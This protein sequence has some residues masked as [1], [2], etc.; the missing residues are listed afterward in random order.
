VSPHLIPQVFNRSKLKL[1]NCTLTTAEFLGNLANRVLVN[2]ASPNYVTLI[3]GQAIDELRK[4][5]LVFRTV[6]NSGFFQVIRWNLWM[7]G[8]TLPLA[9]NQVH[10]DP[11]QPR[12]KR[13]TLPFE[14]CKPRESLMEDLGGD[15]LG[16]F[17][18]GHAPSD[19]GIDPVKISFVQ[20][21]KTT[22]IALSSLNQIP[23]GV[24]L[25][26][27]QIWFP[28]VRESSLASLLS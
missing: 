4:Q 2:E 17:A 10:G 1:F 27:V 8:G 25:N 21:R 24:L 3:V 6:N 20:R 26:N 16:F 13:R 18:A 23:L 19:K 28:R 5:R 15:I 14:S 12:N 22:W 7:L 9:R 11:K